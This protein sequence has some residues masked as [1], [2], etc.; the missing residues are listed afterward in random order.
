MAGDGGDVQGRQ[1]SVANLLDVSPAVQQRWEQ[2]C[3]V[4][5]AM[6]VTHIIPGTQLSQLKGAAPT[7]AS[8][9]VTPLASVER[10]QPWARGSGCKE[11]LG[12]KVCPRHQTSLFCYT[13]AC[14]LK[15]S[16]SWFYGGTG[17]L[18]CLELHWMSPSVIPKQYPTP[19]MTLQKHMLIPV[20][21]LFKRHFPMHHN[22]EIYIC[23][24]NND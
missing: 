4:L 15:K 7:L 10:D 12:G 14:G 5:K 18:L 22:C 13:K 20:H 16:L 17:Q 21:G 9:A 11:R 8:P 2:L 6:D 3:V 19:W 24:R 23:T 1:C